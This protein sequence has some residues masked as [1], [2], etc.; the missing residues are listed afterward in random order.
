VRE[1]S[2]FSADFAGVGGLLQMKPSEKWFPA[3]VFRY[4]LMRAEKVLRC[5]D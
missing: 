1:Q 2:R 3:K 4:A 5:S